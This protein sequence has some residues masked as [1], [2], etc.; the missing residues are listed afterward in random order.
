ML[1]VRHPECG[2]DESYIGNF[3][4]YDIPTIFWGTK[5]AGV[6]ARNLAG[7]PLADPELRPVFVK[8]EEVKNYTD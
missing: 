5:R 6:V 4:V 7:M 8:T 1:C 3:P 2:E